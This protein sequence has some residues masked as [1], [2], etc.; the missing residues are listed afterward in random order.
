MLCTFRLVKILIFAF[1]MELVTANDQ[2][3]TEVSIQVWLSSFPSSKDGH[4]RL[5]TSAISNV[6]KK[7]GAKAIT[8]TENTKFV[9]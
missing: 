8:T 4:W 6:N 2:C 3:R 5:L 9:N 7:S 1:L